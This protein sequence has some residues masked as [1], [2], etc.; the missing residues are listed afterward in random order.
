M[1]PEIG[2]KLCNWTE[3]W[4]GI[5]C[6]L[7]GKKGDRN[8]VPPPPLL[9]VWGEKTCAPAPTIILASKVLINLRR[10]V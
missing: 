10:D 7:T 5:Y 6:K 4:R 3:K 9:K 8:T 1:G 2:V